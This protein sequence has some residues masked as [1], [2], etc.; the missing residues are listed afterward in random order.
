[1]W[2]PI[3]SMEKKIMKRYAWFAL[4][5]IFAMAIVACGG[6]QPTAETPSTGEEAAPTEATTEETPAEE[7]SGPFRAICAVRRTTFSDRKF[8][9]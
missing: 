3:G 9:R 5:L 4:L 2:K 7:A 1:M 8:A 6:T